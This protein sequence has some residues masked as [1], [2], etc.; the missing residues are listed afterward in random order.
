MSLYDI[1]DRV[2]IN[3]RVPVVGGSARSIA[4]V[5]NDGYHV[6]KNGKIV[7]D[8]LLKDADIMA[9]MISKP[10]NVG[11]TETFRKGDNVCIAS[12]AEANKLFGHNFTNYSRFYA[13]DGVVVESFDDGWCAIK[14]CGVYLYIHSSL[15]RMTNET[16]T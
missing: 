14:C 13:K 11:R 6:W 9:V 12:S 15:L 8:I 5:T 16:D 3:S 1:Q 7:T 10:K 4:R 2:L